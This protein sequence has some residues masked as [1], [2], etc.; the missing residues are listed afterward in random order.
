MNKFSRLFIFLSLCSCLFAE[1]G[2]IA[3]TVLDKTSGKPLPGVS[4]I[5]EGAG[6]GADTDEEGRYIIIKIGRAHV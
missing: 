6:L 4:I 1:G 2:K 3:G 5:I